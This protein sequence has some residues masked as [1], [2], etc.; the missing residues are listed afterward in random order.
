MLLPLNK[1]NF[2]HFNMTI[3]SQIHLHFQKLFKRN[4]RFLSCFRQ[5]TGLS[6]TGNS[7]YLKAP[8]FIISNNKVH[9]AHSETVGRIKNLYGSLLCF[10]INAFGKSCRYNMSRFAGLVFC[11]VVIKTTISNNLNYLKIV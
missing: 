1:A 11:V 10:L 2:L 8:Q 4:P 3:K 5:K 6:H 7:I 9:P